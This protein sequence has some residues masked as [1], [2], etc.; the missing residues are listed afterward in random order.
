M[1]MVVVTLYMDGQ[2][3]QEYYGFHSDGVVDRLEVPY[4]YSEITVDGMPERF[5]D[6]AK[7][8]YR[9]AKDAVNELS[10]MISEIHRMLQKD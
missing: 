2:H 3:Y 8:P 4:P 6:Y 5:P 7:A 9:K 1:P 10:S